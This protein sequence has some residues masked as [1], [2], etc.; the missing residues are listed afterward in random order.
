MITK[1]ALGRRVREVRLHNAMTL[2]DVEGL[3]GLSSTHISEIERGMTCP[4]VGALIRIAVALRKDPCY[5]VEERELD[6][7]CVSCDGERPSDPAPRV[8]SADR[9][10]VEPLTRGILGGRIRAHEVR[11]EPGGA[12]E[13]EWLATGEDACFYCVEGVSELS[14]GGKASRV[15]AGDSIQGAVPAGPHG[16]RAGDLG[17]RLLVISDHREVPSGRS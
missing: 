11:L 8:G 15:V 4:T 7:I 6:E 12:I 9:A 16:I 5:F 17:C 1:E 10:A 3:S 13:I 2:K 14:L